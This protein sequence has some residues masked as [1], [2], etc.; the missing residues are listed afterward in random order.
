MYNQIRIKVMLSGKESAAL[1][2]HFR[3][4]TKAN[5]AGDSSKITSEKN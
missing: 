4:E 5:C 1:L 2:C 3:A